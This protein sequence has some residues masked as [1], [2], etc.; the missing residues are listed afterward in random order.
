MTVQSDTLVKIKLKE[1][2]L[3]DVVI[4]NDDKT[5]MDFVTGLLTEIFNKNRQ[6]A[7]NVMLNIHHNGSAVAGTYIFEIAEQKGVDATTI[8]RESGY[9]LTIKINAR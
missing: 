9:P 2:E 5:P 3:F 8:A 4:F 6:E 7:I 1:P